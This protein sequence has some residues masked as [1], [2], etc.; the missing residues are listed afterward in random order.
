[1][2][3]EKDQ[4][5]IDG[6]PKKRGRPPINRDTGPMTPIERYNRY[7]KGKVIIQL[8]VTKK[9]REKFVDI[10]K[11]NN[12]TRDEQITAWVER[13]YLNQNRKGKK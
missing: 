1:M 8:R 3:D 12:L 7:K 10:C 9:I 6:I 2:K 5:T 4:K 13:L 11:E